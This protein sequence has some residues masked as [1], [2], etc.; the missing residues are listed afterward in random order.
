MPARRS[1][2]D[3]GSIQVGVAVSDLDAGYQSRMQMWILPAGDM[4]KE[5][6]GPAEVKIDSRSFQKMVEALTRSYARAAIFLRT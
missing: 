4:S 1:G 2:S 3:G 5:H 6:H